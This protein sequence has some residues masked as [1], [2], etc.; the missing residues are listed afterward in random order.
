MP[1]SIDVTNLKIN[2]L[3]EA[4]YDAAVQ[5]GVI[6]ENEISIITD[7]DATAQ[8]KEMPESTEENLGEIVQFVGETTN[9]RSVTNYTKGYFYECDEGHEIG[10]ATISQTTGNTLSN[11]VVDVSKF[12]E[13][14]Q[15]TEDERVDFN[16]VGTVKE[17]LLKTRTYCG[18]TITI[19]DSAAFMAKL[20][21]KFNYYYPQG[22]HVLCGTGISYRHENGTYSIQVSLGI[23][24]GWLGT[25]FDI[26]NSS[27]EWGVSFSGVVEP[28]SDSYLNI[29]PNDPIVDADTWTKNDVLVNLDDYGISYTGTPTT[30]DVLT[31]NYTLGIPTFKWDRVNTQ[32]QPTATDISAIEQLDSLPAASEA[33][34]GQILQYIGATT[35]DYVS[36]YFYK[37]EKVRTASGSATIS[38]TYGTQ[39]V[40]PSINVTKFEKTEQPETSETVDFCYKKYSE[41]GNRSWYKNG[42]EPVDV[43]QYGISYNVM[44]SVDITFTVVYT[45]G[46]ISYMWVPIE[47]QSSLPSQENNSGKYL[48]T[49][50]VTASWS[51]EPLT[52]K[53]TTDG[54]LAVGNK[55]RATG[56]ASLSL[57]SNSDTTSGNGPVASG[58]NSIAIGGNSMG[59]SFTNHY[60]AKASGNNSIAIG[61]GTMVE[62]TKT[63]SVAISTGGSV[64][65]GAGSVILG[66][67]YNNIYSDGVIVLASN[68][69]QSGKNYEEAN[70]FHIRNG[71]NAY[72][73]MDADGTIPEARL[74]SMSGAAQGQALTLDSN[75]NAV[76]STINPLPSQSGNSGKFLTTNGSSASWATVDALPTQSGQSGKFLTTNGSAASWATVEA[77]PSQTSQS[78]KFLKTDG[79]SANWSK[80]TA[81]PSTTPKLTVTGWTEDLQTGVISQT[82]NVAEVTSTNV[83]LVGPSPLSLNA[84]SQAGVICTEQGNG[85]LTFICDTKP[86]VELTLSIACI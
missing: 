56:T 7:L 33:N 41:P 61:S 19:Y 20:T 25:T 32:P 81:T 9:T 45:I 68:T 3:T 2:T 21:E 70:T 85:T 30:G 53:S 29:I 74:A 49:N 57:G 76:W 39:T 13:I 58:T 6:G 84:Y 64:V 14:E 60:A 86:E 80:V 18:I 31:V 73:M 28:G 72:K 22:D 1:T 71:V 44:P 78:G 24:V 54:G 59:S 40:T 38:Q 34:E 79:T 43:Y 35:S 69:V 27:A 83:V 50:G 67:T 16:F 37:C 4:Q 11:L 66:G 17:P 5:T 51:D 12:E 55:A 36:G 62:A 63:R 42:T 65:S 15:P 26:T 48:T 52:N 46:S 82:I 77:L 23:E 8:T 75:L 10:T 47:V